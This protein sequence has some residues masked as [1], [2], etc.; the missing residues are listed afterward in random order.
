MSI[1]VNTRKRQENKEENV[2]VINVQFAVSGFGWSRV[3]FAFHSFV[4]HE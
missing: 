4:E 2:F 3:A 1:A